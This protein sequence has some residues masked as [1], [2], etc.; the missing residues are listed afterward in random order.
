MVLTVITSVFLINEAVEKFMEP[1][2]GI[3]LS[4]ERREISEIPF[5]AFS[6]CPEVL[7]NKSV[8]ESSHTEIF[9]YG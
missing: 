4:D 8:F 6:V 5:P 1:K 9:P 3:K 7:F 2:V